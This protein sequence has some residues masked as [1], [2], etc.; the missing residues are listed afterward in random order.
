MVARVWHG[1]APASQTTGHLSYVRRQL[2]PSYLTASGN[3]GAL[4]LRRIH[5]DRTEFLLLSLW[6][7]APSLKALTGP[8]IDGAL[9]RELIKSLTG[10]QEL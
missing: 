8:D 7:S 6:D 3:R 1:I 4:L 10:R 9:A 5:A 2:L